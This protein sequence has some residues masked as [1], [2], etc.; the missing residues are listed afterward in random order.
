MTR[1]LH[2]VLVL[3]VGCGASSSETEGQEDTGAGGGPAG[4]A[5]TEELRPADPERGAM[6]YETCASCHALEADAPEPYFGPHLADLFGRPLAADPNYDYSEALRTRGGV[7]TEERLAAYLSA[8][9]DFA[10]GTTMVQ[11]LPDTQDVVDVI[12]YL[13]RELE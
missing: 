13:K 12:A 6:V 3:L 10:P 2:C 4:R 5:A 8:P 9:R 1:L 7:W 11:A